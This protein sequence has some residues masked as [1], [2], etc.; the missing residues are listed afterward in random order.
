M[1]IKDASYLHLDHICP[2]PKLYSTYTCQIVTRINTPI[3]SSCSTPQNMQT[4]DSSKT[5]T[6]VL[7]LGAGVIG[8]SCAYELI[9][10]GYPSVSVIARDL[11]EDIESIGF[12]SPWAV[13]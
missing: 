3:Q 6:S 11:P 9:G 7:I 4:T 1:K 2:Y 10:A 13:S 5:S 8:L 12:S